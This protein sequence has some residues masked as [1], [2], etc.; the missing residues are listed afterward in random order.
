MGTPQNPLTPRPKNPEAGHGYL[1]VLGSWREIKGELAAASLRLSPHP[2]PRP[3]EG[4][5]EAGGPSFDR[6]RSLHGRESARHESGSG[7]REGGAE[8]EGEVEGKEVGV[9]VGEGPVGPREGGF[10]EVGG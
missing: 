5:L 4:R 2:K 9:F 7:R 3:T 8:G 1:W 6:S 10:L